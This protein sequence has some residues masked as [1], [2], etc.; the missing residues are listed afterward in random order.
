MASRK[1]TNRPVRMKDI[2]KDL[3]VSIVTVSKVI[4]GGSDISRATRRRVLKRVK[5]LNYQPNWLARGLVTRKSYT[6]GLV[7]PEMMHSYYAEVAKGL[8]TAILPFGYRLLISNSEADAELERQEIQAL[9]ARQVDGLVISSYQRAGQTGIFDHI[10]NSGAQLVLIDRKIPGLQA[11]FVGW[12]QRAYGAL[13]TEHLIECGYTRI[14]HIHYPRIDS[15]PT[16]ADGYRATL[17]RHGIRVPGSY[18]VSAAT[19][20]GTGYDAMRQLLTLDPPPDAVTCHNDPVAVQAMRAI[21]DAGLKVPDDIAVIGTGNIHY[22]DFLRVPLSTIDQGALLTGQR[23]GELLVRAM[24]SQRRLR[25]REVSIP[26]KLI[27]RES[28]IRKRA[29]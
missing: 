17:K 8:A 1:A 16:R 12:D 14:A 22:S 7:I 25:P 21:L 24:T 3:G 26:P 15:G 9:L 4:R 28:T 19:G 2:A 23:A 20:D 18:L 11:H 13:A 6:V 10:T 5:E 29:A 27:V